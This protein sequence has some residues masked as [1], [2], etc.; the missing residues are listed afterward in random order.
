M[1]QFELTPE[2]NAE[3]QMFEVGRDSRTAHRAQKG[4]EIIDKYTSKGGV[5]VSLDEATANPDAL[6]EL[7]ITIDQGGRFRL[8]NPDA[9]NVPGKY[10]NPEVLKALI[11]GFREAKTESERWS[12]IA[13]VFGYLGMEVPEKPSLEILAQEGGLLAYL[14]KQGGGWLQAGAILLLLLTVPSVRQPEAVSADGAGSD[15]EL[16]VEPMTYALKSGETIGTVAKNLLAAAGIAKPDDHQ[17]WEVI[18]ILAE[19]SDVNV[20]ELGV[21]GHKLEDEKL[22]AGFTVNTGRGQTLANQIAEK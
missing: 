7:G 22:P 18:K 6:S 5:E 20:P 10:E 2:E 9:S 4:A 13:D 15:Y 3:R 19:D 21:T 1:K 12:V 16:T 11:A 8:R 14:R 17:V